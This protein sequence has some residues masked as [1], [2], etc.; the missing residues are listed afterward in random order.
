MAPRRRTEPPPNY[1]VG[2]V[3]NGHIWTG[4]EWVPLRDAPPAVPGVDP[5]YQPGMV[6][7]GFVWTGTDWTA[8]PAL[9]S[10][11]IGTTATGIATDRTIAKG[12]LWRRWWVL[13][14]AA[15]LVIGAF[16]AISKSPSGINAGLTTTP[17]QA[18]NTTSPESS[19]PSAETAS[20]PPADPE[21]NPTNT[22][23]VSTSGLSPA[24]VPYGAK[25]ACRTG[26]PLA[27]VY[28]PY[29]LQVVA[30]CSTVSGMVE[31]VRH[32]DDGDYHIDLALN[33]QYKGMLDAGNVTYQHGWLVVEIVPA[34]EPGCTIGQPPKPA[35][36]T[37]G[38]W[39]A[40]VV[41]TASAMMTLCG[42]A[43][44][45]CLTKR[46]PV[47]SSQLWISSTL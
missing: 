12:P 47:A 40:T 10:P 41:Q 17:S 44:E 46:Q 32:E 3:A 15:L 28:H 20:T 5:L 31:S 24:P 25:S 23:P 4:S 34:D 8:L 35:S 18:P 33:S 37:L 21:V 22:A 30:A 7:N 39:V 16:S 13:A 14:L 36:S 6:A 29:R 1:S 26:N 27:N 9:A 42:P 45:A 11:P 43:S 19:S 38:V 2:S